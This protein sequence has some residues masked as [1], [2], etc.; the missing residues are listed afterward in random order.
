MKRI[1]LSACLFLFLL[2]GCRN[3][4]V[5]GPKTEITRVRVISITPQDVSISIHSSGILASEEETKLSFKTGG[6]VAAVNSREGDNVKKGDVLAVLNLAEIKANVD[7]AGSGYEKALRDWSRA[8]S[9]YADTVATLEQFQNATTALNVAQSNLEIARFNL[10]HSTIKAPSDGV[11][12]KQLV[13]Q[14]ELIAPG[15]PV[16]L[17]G[18]RGKFW[19]V[20]SGLSDRDV[21]RT[22]PGDSAVIVFDAWPGVKFPAVVDL[23]SEMSSPM[24]GTYETEMSLDGMGYRLASGFV[25]DVD[26]FPAKRQTFILV[27]VG[28]VVE[29]EGKKGSIYSVSDSGFAEKHEIR[30][31]TIKGHEAVVSGIPEGITEIVSEGAAYLKAGMKV[32][33]VK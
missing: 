1:I 23:V 13:K 20:T 5:P 33:I 14:N 26:I 15:Y 21:V 10:Q 28:A 30:I 3:E 19:K 11:V 31:E 2:G 25:A 6:I 17:F 18:I 16:F 24:T 12:L 32:E 4:T 7:M 22:N 8:K 9:L 29:A 27:P